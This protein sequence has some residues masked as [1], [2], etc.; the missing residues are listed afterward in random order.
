MLKFVLDKN[1]EESLTWEE[2]EVIGSGN[3]GKMR[4]IMSRFLVDDNGNP[5]PQPTA[6]ETLG[7]LKISEIKQA[8]EA[9]ATAMQEAA[10]NPTSAAKS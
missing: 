10:I 4:E 2:Y 7:K 9:F 3:M 5:I 1:I 6:Y 8:A